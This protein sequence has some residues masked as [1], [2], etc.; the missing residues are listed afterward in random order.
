LTVAI[1]CYY[2]ADRLGAVTGQVR[3]G[4]DD[5][6]FRLKDIARGLASLG[7]I[8]VTAAPAKITIGSADRVFRSPTG[9]DSGTMGGW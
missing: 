3:Q 9:T 4:Y 8:G 7:R 2:L 6:I 1:A 5:A